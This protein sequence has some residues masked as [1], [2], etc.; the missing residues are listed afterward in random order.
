MA[1]ARAGMPA[2]RARA[3]ISFGWTVAAALSLLPAVA[4]AQSTR[5]IG[6]SATLGLDLPAVT[7][8]AADEAWAIGVNPAALAFL[9]ALELAYLHEA[10]PGGAGREGDGLYFGLPLGPL[11]LGLSGEWLG[12]SDALP[13]A[14]TRADRRFS[15]ALAAGSRSASLGV[16]F[17]HHASDDPTRDDLFSW[18]LGAISRPT[19]WLS[20]GVAARDLNTPEA[21][22]QELPVRW[23]LSA[24][25]R[26]LGEWLTV[27]LEAE[28]FE[29]R[30]ET[31]AL[32][33]S[34]ARVELIPGLA[35]LGQ[36][37]LDPE[38]TGVR[39]GGLGLALD[40]DHAGAFGMATA[41][42]EEVGALAGARLSA[43]DRHGLD[44]GGKATVAVIDLGKAMEPP[45]GIALFAPEP[46]VRLVDV[47]E[48]LR[49]LARDDEIDAVALKIGGLPEVGF[50]KAAMLRQAILELRAAGKPVLVHLSGA[51]DVEYYVASAADRIVADKEAALFVNGLVAR[52][53][54][55]GDTLAKI[56]VSVEAVRV[57]T[58]K[59]APDQWLRGEPTEAH[60]EVL[61][62]VLDDTFPRYVAETAAARRM[63]PARF[64]EALAAGVLAPDEALRLGLLDGIAYP[65]QLR[66]EAERLLGRRVETRDVS[67]RPAPY[68][69]WG[70]PPAI[71]V[72]PVEGVIAKGEG[73]AGPLGLLEIA[74]SDAI[75]AAIERA[76]RDEG[77]RAI[78]VWVDS[79]GG[80]AQASDR[81]WQAL[82]DARERKP[83][84]AAMGD[85]AASGGYYV[86]AGAERVFAAPSTLTGSIGIFALKP[87]LAGL[88]EKLEVGQY[89][90]V[91]GE[92]ADLLD[93]SRPWTPAERQALQS[94]VDTSY[95]HF[96]E[97][98]A[99]SRGLAVEAVDAVAQ[100][101]VWT[102]AQAHERGLVDELTGFDGAVAWARKR[103]G[104][105]PDDPVEFR[106]LAPTIGLLSVG[107]SAA[108]VSVG[109]AGARL[110]EP[111][112]EALR[113]RVPPALLAPGPSGTWALGEYAVEVR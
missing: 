33:G 91:R 58:Y 99:R 41:R 60:V 87:S 89:T 57:G 111:L 43:A 71:A 10:P 65:T 110:P 52:A 3:T 15:W 77:I 6:P 49:A 9:P 17:H 83:V 93:P 20:L 74:G 105:A 81:I 80:D 107:G 95:R 104:L 31:R 62:S 5:A 35:L 16:A 96:L 46:R 53:I 69:G 54:F 34:A 109:A 44:Q 63:E 11:A 64:R 18:D 85:V 21:G 94:F 25:L 92:N 113:D 27:G 7:G 82:L 19:R 30:D 24:G 90:T 112:R 84:V 102:G 66:E 106:V 59:N 98:V 79:G 78:L 22:G 86:A 67:P 100:G 108:S 12:R 47:V 56:G 28:L 32:L 103:A 55:F 88:L 39:A 14:G 101:R 29:R 73:G 1:T 8:A 51:G 37:A 76:S 2:L 4:V 40:F 72:I 48:G 50:G 36:F 61:N 68:H 13:G 26:P 42:G 70:R 97:A 75:V 45:S 38:D 23:L